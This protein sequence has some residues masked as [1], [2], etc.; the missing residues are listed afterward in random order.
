M[1]LLA[2]L[3]VSHHQAFIADAFPIRSS[4]S[5]RT[6]G[7]M[8]SSSDETNANNNKHKYTLY[9]TPVS[10]NGARCRLIIYKKQLMDVINIIGP[11]E[12]GGGLKSEEYLKYHPQGKMPLLLSDNDDKTKT[13][14]AIPESDTICRFLLKEFEQQGPSF[15]PDHVVSNILSRFHDLYLTS[16]QGCMYKATPPFGTFGDRWEAIEEFRRQLQILEGYVIGDADDAPYLCGS[17]ITLADVTLF[18]TM[19]F[20]TYMLPKFGIAESE[21][22]PPKL[23]TWYD[24]VSE[25]DADFRK[26]K[27]EVVG[28]LMA[29]DNRDPPRWSTI[30]GAGIQDT[31]PDTI[32]DKII[33]GDIP[34]DIVRE[35]SDWIAFK[36]INPAAPAH[37]LIIPKRRNGLSC[38]R[39]ATPEHAEILGKLLVTAG[40]I[41][42]AKELG[43]GDGARIVI[44]DG[45]DGGQEVPHLHVHVLGGQ[46]MSWPPG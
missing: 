20:A 41:A 6:T 35:D 27:E 44:N 4:G 29:W 25:N 26:V 43:F 11:S 12:L 7:R 42:N 1:L 8:M 10:N 39:R 37:I 46:S 28:G 21:V 9:D 18:P 24:G 2:L 3:A 34:A 14:L 17:D 38:L 5:R 13:R 22:L 33:A 15:Q 40:E 23:R 45:P 31:E 30:W 16:I 19:V 36:D 32:F